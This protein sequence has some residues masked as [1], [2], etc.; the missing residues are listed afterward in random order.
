M[1]HQL[2]VWRECQLITSSYG[3]RKGQS[4][5]LV[6]DLYPRCRALDTAHEFHELADLRVDLASR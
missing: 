2:L 4:E 3:P 1:Q 6:A 5:Y